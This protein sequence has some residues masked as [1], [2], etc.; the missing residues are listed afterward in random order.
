MSRSVAIVTLRVGG[1]DDSDWGGGGG[2]GVASIWVGGWRVS[3]RVISLLMSSV[4]GEGG[5]SRGWG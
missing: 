4:G 2:T 1:W 5:G 3:V